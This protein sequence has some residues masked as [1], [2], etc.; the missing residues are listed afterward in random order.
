[1]GSSR[2]DLL[3]FSDEVKRAI[4]FALYLVQI[5]EMPITAKPLHGFGGGTVQEIVESYSTDAYRAVYTVRF[6]DAVYV[7]H[8]FQKKSKRGRAT[9]QSDVDLINRRLRMAEAHYQDWLRAQGKDG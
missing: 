8:V 6:T 7:L 2:K 4:G 1:M 3:E 9:P 5:G